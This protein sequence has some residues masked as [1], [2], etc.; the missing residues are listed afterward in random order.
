MKSL[1]DKRSR[2]LSSSGRESAVTIAKRWRGPE[3]ACTSLNEEKLVQDFQVRC[4]MLRNYFKC[5]CVLSLRG[6]CRGAVECMRTEDYGST[7]GVCEGLF[8]IDYGLGNS[9]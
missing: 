5:S 2:T 4:L 8:V 3:A 9:R 6:Y 7:I 1:P